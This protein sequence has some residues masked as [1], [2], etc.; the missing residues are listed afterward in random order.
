MQQ[1]NRRPAKNAANGAADVEFAKALDAMRVLFPSGPRVPV[2]PVAPL[3]EE[4]IDAANVRE[5]LRFK[6]G[7]E[8]G[9]IRERLQGER[10]ALSVARYL[11]VDFASVLARVILSE[12]AYEERYREQLP[13]VPW[14]LPRRGTKRQVKGVSLGAVA[15][16]ARA[17]GPEAIASPSV[18]R[19][20]ETLRSMY[21]TSEATVGDRDWW[22]ELRRRIEGEMAAF[23]RALVT[24]GFSGR[25]KGS[26]NPRV[27]GS[28]KEVDR[29][30]KV[31][32]AKLEQRE[33]DP[34]SRGYLAA[35]FKAVSKKTHVKIGT[36]R[37]RRQRLKRK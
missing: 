10:W 22:H 14:V 29:I 15:D 18:W 36:L 11:F 21:A 24:S 20:I 19:M 7:G 26:T 31:V 6:A 34:P 35:S 25:P 32:R 30:A 5:F 12:M 8:R 17:L 37:K 1:R 23:G 13:A 28:V 33:D 2:A 9:R 16:F 4:D 27:A 3:P